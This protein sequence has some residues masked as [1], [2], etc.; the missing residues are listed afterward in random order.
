MTA[1]AQYPDMIMNA[2]PNPVGSGARAIGIGGAFISVVDDATAASWNPGGLVQLTKEEVSIVGSFFSGKAKYSTFDVERIIEEDSP[3]IYRLNYLSVAFP[4]VLFRRN[5]V[6]SLNYQHLYEFYQNRSYT[7]RDESSMTDIYHK[8]HK[9]QKGSLNTISSAFAI[10]IAES[11]TKSFYMGMTCNFWDNDILDNGWENI[12]IQ[13]AEGIDEGYEKISHN[14]IYERYDF[15]G[16]NMNIGFLYYQ[17]L[18]EGRKLQIGGVLKTPFDAR[19]R[20]EQREKLYSEYPTSP[21]LN[22]YEEKSPPLEDL[23]LKMPISYGLGISM[24]FSEDFFL[25][26]DIYRTHWDRYVLKYPSGIEWS[27]INKTK[28]E[29]SPDIKPTTQIRLGSEY[30]LMQDPR[31][32]IPI[33]AGL[34]YDPEPAAKDPDDIFGASLGTGISYN[35]RFSF[36]IAYQF[37]FGKKR[38]AETIKGEDVSSR[39]K[40]HYLYASMIYYFK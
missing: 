27:P 35:E 36:D 3:E 37:R 26:F 23:V 30:N 8:D 16:F 6:F 20:H 10:Q 18:S 13:D 28:L 5:L 17:L 2:T 22:D 33:R 32:V 14:E 1:Y 9:Y 25:A 12:Y 11:S 4:F 38:D 29:D 24:F 40:Q 19:I 34:F 7:W 15:S 21:T 31:K 39:I